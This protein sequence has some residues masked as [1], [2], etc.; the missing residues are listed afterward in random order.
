MMIWCSAVCRYPMG[1]E[2]GRIQNSSI[3]ASSYLNDTFAPNEARL[4][5]NKMWCAAADQQ[6][7]KQ[8]LKV[9]LG[10]VAKVLGVSSQGDGQSNVLTYKIS[11]SQDGS[12]WTDHPA[13]N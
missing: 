2:N 7:T 9:D 11:Y 5:N 10:D 8:W 4:G 13:V 12:S 6:N 3:T 1:M